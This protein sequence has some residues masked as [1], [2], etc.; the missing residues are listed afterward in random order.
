[1]TTYWPSI[2]ATRGKDSRTSRRNVS[3]Q[4]ALANAAC[5]GVQ[6]SFPGAPRRRLQRAQAYISSVTTTSMAHTQ[7]IRRT[8]VLSIAN[9]G[10]PGPTTH[11]VDGELPATP[12]ERFNVA[13]VVTHRREDRMRSRVVCVAVPIWAK[14]RREVAPNCA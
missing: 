12:R 13:G 3:G 10:L 9:A 7:H 5:C 14:R 4:V 1:M 8:M 6:A 2:L 11:C